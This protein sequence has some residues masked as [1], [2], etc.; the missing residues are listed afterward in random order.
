MEFMPVSMLHRLRRFDQS[1]AGRLST[2]FD[3]GGGAPRLA[4][5]KDHRRRIVSRRGGCGLQ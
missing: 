4:S 3:C 5:I 1:S 2:F